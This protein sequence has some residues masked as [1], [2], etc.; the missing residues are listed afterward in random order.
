MGKDTHDRSADRIE[1]ALHVAK[2]ARDASGLE[3]VRRELELVI[4]ILSDADLDDATA[5][6]ERA[7][8]SA[9]HR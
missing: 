7:G 3:T 1:R 5:A 9:P 6:N 8:R 4:A 2:Q